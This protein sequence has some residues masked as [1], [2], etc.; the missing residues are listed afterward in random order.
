MEITLSRIAE[1]TGGTLVGDGSHV[2]RG[3]CSPGDARSDMLCIVW[4]KNLLALVPEGVPVL[5]GAGTVRG[6]DGVEMDNPKQALPRILPMF[7]RRNRQEP[8]IHPS[9]TLHE[10]CIIGR[11]VAIGPGCVVSKGARVG[12]RSRL[13]ANV[14]VGESVVVGEDCSL[15]AGVALL[16]FVEI[17]S[18]VA[19][20]SGVKIGCDGFGFIPRESGE[21]EKIPQIGTVV[22]GDDVEI[23]ANGSVD[24]ATFG[25]TRIG[26]GTKLGA[27]VHVAHNCEIGK[28]CVMAGYV[29]LGGSTK[30]GDGTVVAGLVGVADHVTIG[31]GV[32]IAGRSGVT[33][34]I[35]DGMTVSG[36]PAQEHRQEN[37]FQASLRRVPSYSERLRELEREVERLRGSLTERR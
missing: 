20:H 27:L 15:E 8:G 21:W 33:K 34:N 16:D 23:G 29:A 13:Q 35:P 19:I 32:T 4:E 17:G 5:S 28:N 24:R 26:A 9:A 30:V 37:R 25:A 11:D 36:F 18:R 7:D 6:R 10:S 1:L 22:I 12:D 3:L 31:K 14:F 2:V